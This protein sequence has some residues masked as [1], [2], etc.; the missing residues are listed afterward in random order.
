MSFSYN[1][2]PGRPCF[3]FIMNMYEAV[4]GHPLHFR[5]VYGQTTL[6]TLNEVVITGVIYFVVIFGGQRLMVNHSA[7][8]LQKL[9]RIH[10][11]LLTLAS[12]LLLVLLTEQ[13][14]PLLY[15]QGFF[16]AVCGDDS[17]HSPLDLLYYLNYL[18]K[19]WELLDTV[20]LVL[21]KKRLEFLHYFHHSMTLLLCFII[22]NEQPGATW[23]PIVLNLWVH[24]LMYYYYYRTAAGVHIWWK[25]YLTTMQITQFVLDLTVIVFCSYTYFASHYF[26]RMP[27]LGHCTATDFSAI[28]APALLGSYLVLFIN[29]YRL[30][31]QSKQSH[32][33]KRLAADTKSL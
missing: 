25:K 5:Y 22:Q 12:G 28:F 33:R 14:G 7:F 13:I 6:S 30:T 4:T 27:H 24:V 17:W 11:L 1:A 32:R 23:V 9:S 18:L 8:E 3:R 26:P 31:Y 29:F 10:N 2:S 16:H 21:R 19:Y 20:F 15:H